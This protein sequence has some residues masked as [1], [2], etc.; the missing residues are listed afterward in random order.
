MLRSLLLTAVAFA[1]LS[2][3]AMAASAD[4]LL[5]IQGVDGESKSQNNLKQLGLAATLRGCAGSTGPGRTTIGGPEIPSSRDLAAVV[6]GGQP[7]RKA[8]LFIRKTG[9]DS[10]MTV[11]LE[12]VM[13][14]SAKPAGAAGGLPTTLTLNY[15][16]LTWSTEGGGCG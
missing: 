5:V 6:A 13:I 7:I 16:G 2:G 10:A 11:Q 3:S 8:I 12:N 4:Y 9:G 1:S 15:G 14:T